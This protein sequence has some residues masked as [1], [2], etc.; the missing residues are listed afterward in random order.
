MS[1]K[2]KKLLLVGFPRSIHV[3]RWVGQLY[4][5]GWD[6]HLYPSQG[7]QVVHPEL[8]NV[9][10]HQWFYSK[11]ITSNANNHSEFMNSFGMYIDAFR[12]KIF[13]KLFPMHRAKKLSQLIN[14]LRPDVVHSLEIQGAGYLI[15]KARK[16]HI[17][18]FPPWIVT[19]WGSDIYLFGRLRQH[20]NKIREV[21]SSCD[22]YSCE[23]ERDVKLAQEFG[24]NKKILPVFPNTGGF[25]LGNLERPRN[26]TL[27]SKRKLI[28]LKGYQDW[29]GRALV[30]LRALERCMDVLDGYEIAIHSA[31]PDVIIAAELLTQK[32]K[33]PTRII[34][35]YTS[36]NAML[37]LHAGSR[38][39]IGVSISDAISTSLLEAM[40]MG[41]FPIQSCTACAEEWIQDG[42]SGMIVPPED[43]DIIEMALRTALSN[44]KLVDEAAVINWQVAQ[45]RLDGKQLRQKTIDMYDTIWE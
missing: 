24:F 28:V 21:L 26:K 5:Q 7:G 34:P 32:T 18:V 38:I 4:G 23:C 13:E 27:T 17:G 36:H 42:V 10:V 40:V 35:P 3:A 1:N 41:A 44:D 12:R 31:A 11:C 33:I 39:S 45:S 37:M 20:Q 19:N 30:G 9:T 25:D 2:R 29:A 8:S 14:K 43:P 22:Y 16:I 6:I 15:L